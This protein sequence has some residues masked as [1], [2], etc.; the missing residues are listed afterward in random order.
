M[1]YRPKY[2]G[3]FLISIIERQRIRT[4]VQLFIGKDIDPP[5]Y[6][7]FLGENPYHIWQ[8]TQRFGHF[9]SYYKHEERTQ[10]TGTMMSLH[11]QRY[12]EVVHGL[13]LPY[14]PNIH[15]E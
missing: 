9:Y 1:G 13:V 2:Y 14:R 4:F 3:H 8:P 15:K 6:D 10:F 11:A 5:H 12:I 7:V